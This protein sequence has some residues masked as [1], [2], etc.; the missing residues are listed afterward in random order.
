M[1]NDNIYFF[2]L[3]IGRDSFQTTN[4]VLNLQYTAKSWNDIKF[5]DKN[6]FEECTINTRSCLSTLICTI[7]S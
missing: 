1:L 7:L 4:V 5:F 2:S 3:T 6:Q